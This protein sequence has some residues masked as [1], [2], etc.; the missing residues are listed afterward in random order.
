MAPTRPRPTPTRQRPAG[1]RGGRGSAP[2]TW[3]G[4]KARATEGRK[5]S[6]SGGVIKRLLI[7]SFPFNCL[8]RAW[9]WA[10]SR[11]SM[12]LSC[13]PVSPGHRCAR[14][15]TEPERSAGARGSRLGAS[16]LE[17]T[18]CHQ[19]WPPVSHAASAPSPKPPGRCCHQ[20][21]QRRDFRA[22]EPSRED[23]GL[24]SWQ[25][26]APSPWLTLLAGG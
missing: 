5:L 9:G 25:T 6:L 19:A 16:G 17:A 22:V 14:V 7:G 1:A 15:H 8:Q 2:G 3:K 18:L 20:E 12:F 23:P 13:H 26:P 24:G 10:P 21:T 11:P 4:F